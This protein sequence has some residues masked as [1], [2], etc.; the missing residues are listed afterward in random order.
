MPELNNPA[1]RLYSILEKVMLWG[2]ANANDAWP[3]QRVWVYAMGLT[4][5]DGNE[6]EMFSDLLY[7]TFLIVN[8]CEDLIKRSSAIRQDI[9]L[10]QLQRVKRVILGRGAQNWGE[11]R[12]NFNDDFMVSLQLAAENLSHH[13]YEEAVPEEELTGIQS[14]IEELTGR[15]LESDLH[16]ELKAVL[17]AGL[18]EVRQAILNYRIRGAD[19]IRKAVDSN[20]VAFG[21]NLEHI[22]DLSDDQDK[23]VV[24]AY[25]SLID[26]ANEIT[27][28]ALRLKPLGEGIAEMLRIGG[29]G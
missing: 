4:S 23:E 5:R 26:R 9:Y 27:T 17:T 19:E 7:E 18:E 15:I 12:S 24:S 20:I 11:Y 22:A 8:S 13:W 28:V 10:R 14:E 29:A 1:T 6:E 25:R 2:D 3:V 21:R 16:V